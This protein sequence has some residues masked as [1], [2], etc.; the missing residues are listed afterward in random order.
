M[1]KS[2]LKIAFFGSGGIAIPALEFLIKEKYNIVCF[3]T[4]QDAQKGRH[5]LASATP[6]K[7][8]ALKHN[9]N[10]FQPQKIS[11]EDARNYLKGLESDI[12][13]VF[14]FGKILP[15]EIL[16]I[17]KKYPLNIHASLLPKYRGAAPINWALINGEKKTG[18]TIIRMNEKMDSGDIVLK[19]ELNISSDDNAVTLDDKLAKLAPKAL[20]EVLVSIENGTISFS[21]QNEN[22]VSFAPK[23]K[24]EDAKISWDKPAQDI[25]N[26]IRGLFSWPGTFTLYKGKVLKIWNAGIVN[27]ISKEKHHPGTIIDFD[28]DGIIVASKPGFVL[29]KEL[30]LESGKKTSAWNFIQGHKIGKGEKFE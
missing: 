27:I 6:K 30:Q 14:S 9:L 13:I 15:K 24:K 25:I 20:K 3:V 19:N 16:G 22:E 8:I 5:L 11:S 18:I 29:I 17:P 12:F 2:K 26:Q 4:A 28:K 1:I 7:D 10:V 23:L 21:R